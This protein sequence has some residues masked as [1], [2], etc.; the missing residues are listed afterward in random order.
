MK[1]VAQ[2]FRPEFSNRVDKVVV[3]HPLVKKP[4]RRIAD[5]EISFLRKRVAERDMFLQVTAAALDRLGEPGFGPVYG[6]RP[7]WRTLREQLE[8]PLAQEIL[9][10]PFGPGDTVLTDPDAERL[11]C[12]PTSSARQTGCKARAPSCRSA[13]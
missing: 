4:F 1:I 6:A 2:Y 8:S 9:S 12:R 10:G 7:L 3:F 13:A 5:I 11:I